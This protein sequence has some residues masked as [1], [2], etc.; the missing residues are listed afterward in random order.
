MRI[1]PAL[2]EDAKSIAEVHVAAWQAAYRGLMPDAY[3]DELTV[4]KRTAVWQRSLALPSPGTVV[5][6]ETKDSLAGFCL[7]GPT[8]DED[9]KNKSAGE[10][11]AINIRPDCWRNGFGRALCDLA[12]GEAPRRGWVL[13]TLWVLNG[14]QR[15]RRFY[16]SLGFSLD[17][18]DRIDTKL[19]GAPLH[20][21][22]YR[23][24]V[25]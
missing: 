3:L 10:I 14:N 19:I 16:E 22:R 12:L 25:V 4:E 17:G 24:E 15:A 6:A 1:R 2:P 21:L 23:K 8:R 5:V 20:E 11:L 18:T 7:F 13:V 9:G